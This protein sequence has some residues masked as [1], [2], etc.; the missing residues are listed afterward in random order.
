MKDLLE[1]NARGQV[2]GLT[3]RKRAKNICCAHAL[4][5]EIAFIA[6]G[7]ARARGSWA[8]SG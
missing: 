5:V 3:E 1:S 8:V 6:N 4:S 7:D 2:G